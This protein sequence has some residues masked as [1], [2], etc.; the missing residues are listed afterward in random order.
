[1][2]ILLWVE[3]A[4]YVRLLGP[5]V[6]KVASLPPEKSEPRHIGS[7]PPGKGD[8]GSG[9]ADLARSI[10]GGRNATN[11][12]PTGTRQSHETLFCRF[13]AGLSSVSSIDAPNVIG[14]FKKAGLRRG[15]GARLQCAID[16]TNFAV[17]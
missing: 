4:V 14:R 13:L 1:M 12:C 17:V 15:S 16:H 6:H 8:F 3:F 2:I 10:G 9:D 11:K 5:D 7:S